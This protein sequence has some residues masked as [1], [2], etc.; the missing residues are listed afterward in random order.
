MLGRSLIAFLFAALAAA[1]A[2]AQAGGTSIPDPSGIALFGMG[3]AGVIIGRHF[4]RRRP[5]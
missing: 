5:D 3:L 4:S 1:P 2:L